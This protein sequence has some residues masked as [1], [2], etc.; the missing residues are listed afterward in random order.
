V[1]EEEIHLYVVYSFLNG[2]FK[3]F[4]GYGKPSFD[5][6]FSSDLHSIKI[7][8]K[9]CKGFNSYHIGPFF[10]KKMFVL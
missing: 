3:N 2:V 9:I 4:S 6:M 10:N 5:S 7:C 8:S 1:K